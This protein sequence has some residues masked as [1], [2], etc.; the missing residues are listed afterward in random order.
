MGARA[1][2]SGPTKDRSLEEIQGELGSEA[3]E[4]ITRDAALERERAG[5]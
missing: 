4:P 2:A 1:D 3:D 5:A